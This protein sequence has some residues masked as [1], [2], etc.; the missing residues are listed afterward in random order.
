M[1]AWWSYLTVSVVWG[2]TFLGIAYAVESFTPFGLSAARFLPAGLIALVISR[3]R[4]ERP[5][6]LRDL[7][8]LAV[9]G[10][11]LLTVCMALIAW[12]EGR[13][14]SGVA[15]TLA[16]TVPLFLGLMEPRGLDAKSWAG[17]GVGF[18]GI[19]LILWP[20]GQSPQGAGSMALLVSAALWSF[21]TLYGRRHVLQAGHFSQ[22]GIEMLI[23]G[24][25]SLLIAP[26]AGGFTHAPVTS[27]SALALVYLIVFGSILAYSAYIF[28]AKTW[29]PARTGT[30]AYWNPVVGLLL[31]CWIGGETLHARMLPGLLL[32]LLGI[33][34]VQFPWAPILRR[35]QRLRPV[36]G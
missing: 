31:G 32:V 34:L 23:A 19:L 24:L 21:G 35:L 13:V 30:Y 36:H 16:A 4:K 25:L 7:P 15:A 27:R 22:V 1:L 20:S 8:H 18:L 3:A 10:V 6:T 2:S 17:L 9:V 11:L 12:A 26:L 28:L 33:G 5:P 29:S 14:N